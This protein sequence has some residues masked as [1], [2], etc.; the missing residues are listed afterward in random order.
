[1]TTPTDTADGAAPTAR[2]TPSRTRIVRARV[3]VLERVRNIYEARD[4]LR[5]MV[6]KELK[7]KYKGSALGFVWS[8]L[9]PMMYLVIFYLVF[10]IFLKNGIPLFP[11]FLLSG[12]MVWNFI[13]SVLPAAT[14]SV[15]ANGALVKKVAF[16]RE[17][18]PLATVG[19]GMVHFCLQMTVLIAGLAAFRHGIDWPF[20]T[21]VPVAILAMVLLASGLAILL[22]AINVYV[23]DAQHLIELTLL[24]WFW[25]TPIAY[26]FRQVG[27]KIQ[28]HGLPFWLLNLNPVVP[29]TTVFQRAFYADVTVNNG[30]LPLLPETSVLFNLTFLGVLI[31]F[32]LALLAFALRTFGRLETR[33]AEEI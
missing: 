6:R 26:P 23:R 8:L 13:G 30:T 1:M 3:P 20:L 25:L 28:A 33:F 22:S 18:L 17:I 9:N 12:L 2:P 16:P 7:V 24:A 5:A 14:A 19:A 10:S 11:I 32:S 27:D 31:A 21:I 4:L 29:I 15:V